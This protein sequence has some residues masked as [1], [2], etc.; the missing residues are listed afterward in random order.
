M[1]HRSVAFGTLIYNYEECPRLVMLGIG[2]A[3]GRFGLP[4]LPEEAL[5]G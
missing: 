2:R 1:A 4:L 5:A 3:L